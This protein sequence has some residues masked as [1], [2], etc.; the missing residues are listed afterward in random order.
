MKKKRR[1]GN[2]EGTIFE[3]K[4]IKDGQVNTYQEYL[5]KEKLLENQYMEKLKK[6]F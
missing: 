5:Q 2:G 1:R 4:K 6:R 3:D